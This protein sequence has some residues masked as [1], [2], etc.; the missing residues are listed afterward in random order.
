MGDL[1]YK[2]RAEQEN[3][4]TGS[5]IRRWV[6]ELKNVPDKHIHTPWFMSEAE[7]QDCG[8]AIGIDYPVSLVGPLEIASCTCDE[9][10][11]EAEADSE[12]SAEQSLKSSISGL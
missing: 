4:P 1:R 11:N 8:C 12:M 2:L 3:D 5:Y 7:M 9:N 10:M 6:P